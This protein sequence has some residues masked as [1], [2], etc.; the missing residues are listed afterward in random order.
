MLERRLSRVGLAEGHTEGRGSLGNAGPL[1]VFMQSS[2]VSAVLTSEPLRIR[3]R[4]E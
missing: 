2:K 4:P 1:I 3:A